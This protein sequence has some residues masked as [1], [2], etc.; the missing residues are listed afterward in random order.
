MMLPLSG[1][2]YSEKLVE[3]FVPRLKAANV[4]TTAVTKAVEEFLQVFQ[5]QHFGPGSSI[6]F[7]HSTDG[8]LIVRFLNAEVIIFY[9]CFLTL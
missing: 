6:F 1:K 4:Y 7:T 3:V 2:E 8:S 9:L 5:N